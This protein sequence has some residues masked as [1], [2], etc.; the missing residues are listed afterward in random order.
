M[1]KVYD[2]KEAVQPIVRGVELYTKRYVPDNHFNFLDVGLIKLKIEQS[3]AELWKDL[4][5][6][7]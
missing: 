7:L 3:A 1:S 4:Q 5:I 2:F 6:G